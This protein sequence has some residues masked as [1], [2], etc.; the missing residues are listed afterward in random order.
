MTSKY[1]TPERIDWGLT[2]DDLGHREY[3]IVFRVRTSANISP[4]VIMNLSSLPQVG[5]YWNFGS[6]LDTYATCTPYMKVTPYGSRGMEAHEFWIVEQ[7]FTSKAR[8][9]CEDQSMD[10]PLL[11]PQ[12]MSGGFSKY[13]K[14]VTTDKDGNPIKTS[15]FETIHGP[16]VEF[17]HNR[18]SIVV[19]QNS[20]S[21][22]HSTLMGLVDHVNTSTMW[23]FPARTVKLSNISWERRFWG[24]CYFYYTR[25]LEF[26]ID[27]N[28]WDKTALDEGTKCLRGTWSDSSPPTWQQEPG[29]DVDNPT[30]FIR[31]KDANDEVAH[32]FLDGLG[33]PVTDIDDAATISVQYYPE[34]GLN[35]AELGIPTDLETIQWGLT[36]TAVF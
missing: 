10:D 17:D 34:D 29:L 11:E 31:Y 36:P 15:S 21:L 9:R 6:S 1:S 27:L 26:E 12:Q 7:K 30:H 14:E 19:R 16:A 33:A 4:G 20:P 5:D 25:I 22:A 2:R 23:G 8:A 32:C 18:P 35:F 28:T 24:V 13:V 3:R